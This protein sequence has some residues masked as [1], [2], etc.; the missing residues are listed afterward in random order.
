MGYCAHCILQT[1]QVVCSGECSWLVGCCC[2]L[3]ESLADSDIGRMTNPRLVE[4][5]LSDR[6]LF[7]ATC[8]SVGWWIGDDVDSAA[9]VPRYLSELVEQLSK[10]PGWQDGGHE[11]DCTQQP[12]TCYRCLIEGWADEGKQILEIER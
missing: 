9:D 8:I 12:A 1:L 3:S 11:G 4:N 2:L 6:A 7:L 10:H 5:E